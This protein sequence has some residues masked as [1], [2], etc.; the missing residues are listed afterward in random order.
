MNLSIFASTFIPDREKLFNEEVAKIKEWC[1]LNK[2][3]ISIKPI[4][5]NW[6]R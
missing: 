4:E 2:L 3:S 6:R 1:N 5:A